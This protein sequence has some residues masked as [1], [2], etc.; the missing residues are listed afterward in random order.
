MTCSASVF[1]PLSGVCFLPPSPVVLTL[2]FT[3]SYKYTIALVIIL[4][5]LV[6][7]SLKLCAFSLIRNAVLASRFMLFSWST[8]KTLKNLEILEAIIYAVDSVLA[9]FLYYVMLDWEQDDVINRAISIEPRLTEIFLETSAYFTMYK[10]AALF[11]PVE[12]ASAILAALILT[13]YL[14]SFRYTYTIYVSL[15]Y[16]GLILIVASLTISI[17]LNCS[18]NMLSI[19]KFLLLAQVLMSCAISI[20]SPISGLTLLVPTP[21]VV[22]Y[23][24]GFDNKYSIGMTIF[25]AYLLRIS[26]SLCSFTII[27]NGMVATRFAI[28]TWSPED[29]ARYVERFETVYYFVEKFIYFYPMYKMMVWEQDEFL[30]TALN[31]D[32]RLVEVFRESSTYFAI[33]RRMRSTI[34]FSSPHRKSLQR[35]LMYIQ[36]GTI[37]AFIFCAFVPVLSSFVLPLLPW[38]IPQW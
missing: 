31:V 18:T 7:F 15:T 19:Y 35:K 14:L 11:S 36:L 21:M 2:N 16:A 3:F 8:K 29:T 32:Q 27:R 17:I 20:C 22:S 38:R 37:M 5:Y 4:F 1:I 33:H 9:F 34:F 30:N 6:R 26:L 28:S 13:S 25:I 23:N 10:R 24:F 12:S